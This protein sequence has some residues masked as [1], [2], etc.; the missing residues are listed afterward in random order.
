M[1]P[2]SFALVARLHAQ[3]GQEVAERKGGAE[4]AGRK[5]MSLADERAM[6]YK[7]IADGLAG[8]ADA[9]MQE[10]RDPLDEVEEK[11]L[12]QAVFDSLYGLGRIQPL[13][14]AQPGYTDIHIAGYDCVWLT[15]PDG[16]K[17]RGERVADSDEELV[18]MIATAARRLGRSE[19]RW[20]YAH[21]ELDMQLPNGDRLHA[22]MAVTSRPNVTI[23]RHSWAIN[24]LSQ[25]R[26]LGMIDERL[27]HF[28]TCAVRA[29]R[30]IIVGGGTG[31]GK[32][33]MLRC[34]INAILE[35]ERLITV[36]D[37][38]ELGLERFAHLHPDYETL[39]AR[40]ANIEGVG[41]F[42]MA[43]LV[44]SGLRMD[45]HRVIV[46]EVRGKEVLPMLL[47]MS[48]GN[49]GSMCSVH[50]ESSRGVFGRLVMYAA[51]SEERLDPDVTNLLVAEAVH[52]VV[53]VGW[54][55]GVRCV[56]SVR[57]V[58]GS[59]GQQVTTNE[60]FRPGPDGRAVPGYPL[61]E[62]TL[63]RLEAV[64]FDR[65]VLER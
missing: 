45:P 20:D 55:N 44:R 16:R 52:L 59:D 65:S 48:Q 19:R 63:A 11:E 58:T 37:S 46:G 51:M 24:L 34:L 32:T 27:E 30:N 41:E 28:L 26:E 47:A 13:L 21:P 1:S 56:T 9:A 54:A 61:Q 29:R 57:E 6:A 10:G 64:G 35:Y 14:D 18:D 43:D 42:S 2:P 23:R 15:L 60:I 40:A 3:V 31:T 49:D 7:L 4:D 36:E 39:E 25:L 53:H 62:Q 12:G 5:R 8:L 22:L 33:T 50:A 17:V 38:L